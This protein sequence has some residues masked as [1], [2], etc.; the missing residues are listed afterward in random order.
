MRAYPIACKARTAYLPQVAA[1]APTGYI[2]DPVMSQPPKVSVVTISYNH[3]QYI[4]EAVR[5]V[6]EQ[7]YDNLEL[8]VSDDCSTDNSRDVL[9][10][11]RKQSPIAMTV[12]N[13]ERNLG[14]N[15]NLNQAIRHTTGDY[16]AFCSSDDKFA[17]NRFGAQVEMLRAD[18]GLQIVYANGRVFTGSGVFGRLHGPD[19]IGLLRRPA[20][21]ILRFLY[22]HVSPFYLQT[23]LVRRDFLIECRGY[24]EKILADDWV[25]NIRFFEKL[26]KSGLHAYIDQDVC[27]Y[28][29]HDGN[30]FR[31]TRRHTRLMKEVVRTYTPR[32]LKREASANIYWAI[33]ENSTL[34]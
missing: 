19:V 12:L 11:L 25:M 34:R 16:I 6:W 20:A 30:Q 2:A 5:S 31:N 9:D 28:R 14:I 17:P 32:K 24:D 8:V 15:A 10:D 33:S 27:R 4:G 18:P 26:A 7:D 1:C 22:T 29:M 23:V 3:A 13:N 21:D